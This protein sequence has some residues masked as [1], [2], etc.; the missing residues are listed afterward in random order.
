M[1]FPYADE[2]IIYNVSDIT[3]GVF[4][5]GLTIWMTLNRPDRPRISHLLASAELTLAGL[6]VR[7]SARILRMLPGNAELG[8]GIPAVTNASTVLIWVLS[9]VLFVLGMLEAANHVVNVNEG[10]I[11]KGLAARLSVS[12]L[13]AA[14]GIITFALT[15]NFKAFSAAIIIQLIYYILH[16]RFVLSADISREF[17]HAALP[18]LIIFA[19]ALSFRFARFTGPGMTIM[20]LI[21]CEQ[22]QEHL[23]QALAEKE[24]ELAKNRVQLLT[25]QISPHYIYNSL[26]S[27]SGLCSTEP[28]KASEAINAFSGYLRGSLESLTRENMIPFA[29]ELEHTQAYLELEKIAGSRRFGVEYD[30]R[31][32]D[33]MLPPLVLQPVVENAVKHGAAR[34]AAGT[35]PGASGTT[36]ISIATFEHDGKIHIEVTDFS[37]GVTGAVNSEANDE[38]VR[39]IEKSDSAIAGGPEKKSVGLE[40]VRTRLAIQ[41]GGTLEISSL[42]AGTR[43]TM[44]IAALKETDRQIA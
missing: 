12:C 38:T 26:Q 41:C 35:E 39:C 20:L 7:I 17:G 21:I 28:A 30:L 11:V 24:R 33:F 8:A 34:M 19:L 44:T 5:A 31:V 25:D 4:I 15:G 16:F 27:I 3:S 40:N 10:S 42:G 9:F 36:H 6:F 43:V 29:R 2:N 23:R 32:T 14:G 18:V 22:Y 37:E 13:I 1:N